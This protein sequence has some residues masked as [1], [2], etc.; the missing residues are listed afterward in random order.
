MF[1]DTSGQ[2]ASL[3][4]YLVLEVPVIEQFDIGSGDVQLFGICAL[5]RRATEAVLIFKK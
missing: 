1:G 5:R 3:I 4:D 2:F